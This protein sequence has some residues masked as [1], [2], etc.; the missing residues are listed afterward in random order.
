MG[1]SPAL[2]A[3]FAVVLDVALRAHGNDSRISSQET[4]PA[5]EILAIEA[6][7]F[8][9]VEAIVGKMMELLEPEEEGESW[10]TKF[11]LMTRWAD[12][13]LWADLVGVLNKI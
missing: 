7:V 2:A 8:W 13:D 12:L 10:A 11:S 1:P 6:E 9:L 5:Q 4:L 3:I